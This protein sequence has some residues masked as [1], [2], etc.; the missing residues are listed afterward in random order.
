MISHLLSTGSDTGRWI[1]GFGWPTLAAWIVIRAGGLAI[2]PRPCWPASD[3]LST[4]ARRRWPPRWHRAWSS[5]PTPRAIRRAVRA[6]VRV[7]RPRARCE[8]EPFSPLAL[9][10]EGGEVFAWCCGHR[11]A[12]LSLAGS[13]RSGDRLAV[14]RRHL[15][16][17]TADMAKPVRA[18]LPR[19]AWSWSGRRCSASTSTAAEHAITALR[20]DQRRHLRLAQ[21]DS[22]SAPGCLDRRSM[23]ATGR[24]VQDRRSRSHATPVGRPRRGGREW[25]NKSPRKTASRST[26]VA[27]R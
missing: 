16:Q 4:A 14:V 20:L 6:A 13:V 5:W 15:G 1:R 17:W 9:V 3:S 11:R 18:N 2:G 22:C 21:P 19:L 8:D 12:C 26:P 27:Y 7:D 24:R 25:D 10:D 23:L